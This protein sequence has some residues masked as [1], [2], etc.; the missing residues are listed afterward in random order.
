MGHAFGTYP[1]TVTLAYYV[2]GFG[3]NFKGA[4]IAA[5]GKVR[6]LSM[7]YVLDRL[8][9]LQVSGIEDDPDAMH[10][11]LYRN[12]LHDQHRYEYDY[13]S[14]APSMETQIADLVAALCRSSWVDFSRPENQVV[15]R[16]LASSEPNV[17]NNFFHQLLLS[18]ELYLRINTTAGVGKKKSRIQNEL[19]E[20]IRWDLMLAQRWLENVE[21]EP[22]RK[23]KSSGHGGRREEKSNVGFKFPNKKQQVEALRNFAWTLKY[24]HRYLYF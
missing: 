16:F 9:K 12:L 5:R 7:L 11:H 2:A 22:P 21:I 1:G 8:R 14:S 4:E 6:K 13:P 18:V 19:P 17:A 20:K 3:S 10:D 24:H 15:A 23:V